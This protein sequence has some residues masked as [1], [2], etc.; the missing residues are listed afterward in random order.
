VTQPPA[1]APA[2]RFISAQELLGDGFAL[3]RRILDSGWTPTCLVGVWRGGAP[4]AV[5]VQEALAYHGVELRH[6]VVGAASY[7]GIELRGADV[8]VW[9]MD[10]LTETLT[11]DDRLLVVDDVFD[12]GRTI[13]AVLNALWKVEGSKRPGLVRTAMPWYKPA[14]N[15]T[16]FSP[17]YWLHETSDWLVFPHELRG[18]S[19]EDIEANKPVD[20]A[21]F[22]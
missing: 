6:A 3:A 22:G 10:T 8:R 7:T 11:P 1:D 2:K 9:G 15:Q 12:T 17:D 18:L 20:A 13:E 4:V 16:R 21:F 14:R 5:T 19:R